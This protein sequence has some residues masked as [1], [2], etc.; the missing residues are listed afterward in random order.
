M[1]ELQLP[2]SVYPETDYLICRKCK[3]GEEVLTNIVMY[4]SYTS[5]APTSVVLT[6]A[7]TLLLK[8]KL[9]EILS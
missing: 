3:D 5:G 1:T 8:Q 4:N 2:C 7:D 6:L 9:E